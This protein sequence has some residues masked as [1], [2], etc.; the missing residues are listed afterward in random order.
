MYVKTTNSIKVTATPVYLEQQSQPS[1]NQYIWAYTIHLENLGKETVQLLRRHW[2]ITN[3]LGQVQEVDGDGVIGEQPV[4][5][6][7]ESYQ[8]TSGTALPTPSGIM[9]GHYE[10]VDSGTLAEFAVEVPAF[11]LD[12][13]YQ[14]VRAH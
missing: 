7:G 5:K 10:M 8:Y 6:P 9:V 12:S 14:V 1:E 13:P 2:E 11:S 3:N 4:L